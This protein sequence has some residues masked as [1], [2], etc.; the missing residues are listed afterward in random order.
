MTAVLTAHGGNGCECGGVVPFSGDVSLVSCFFYRCRRRLLLVRAGQ[1][2]FKSIIHSTQR[3]FTVT[4]VTEA[5][6]NKT[7]TTSNFFH[8]LADV[9]PKALVAA[10]SCTSF[11]ALLESIKDPCVELQ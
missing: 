4:L 7:I 6:T 5:T 8:S 9:D 2:H 3:T 10:S 1:P 11:L